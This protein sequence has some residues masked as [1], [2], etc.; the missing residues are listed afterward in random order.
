MF[1]GELQAFTKVPLK[2]EAV[3]A[4]LSLG[5]IYQFTDEVQNNSSLEILQFNI[6]QD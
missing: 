2:P 3:A 5:K 1:K 4:D 6:T